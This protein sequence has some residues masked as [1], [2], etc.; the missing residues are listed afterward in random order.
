MEI[1]QA[2]SIHRFHPTV[3]TKEGALIALDEVKSLAITKGLVPVINNPQQLSQL[4]TSYMLT[5]KGIN[6]VVH[7]PLTSEKTTFTLY[8][9][10]SLPIM[11]GTKVFAKIQS[12]NEIISVGTE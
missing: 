3:L 4:E 7:L 5:Q 10:N 8:K 12:K 2:A 9:Y 6:L 11:I 1:I